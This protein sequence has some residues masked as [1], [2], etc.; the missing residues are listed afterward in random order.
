MT[1]PF[2]ASRPRA[3]ARAGLAL[4][5]G[6]ALAG[7]LKTGPYDPPRFPFAAGFRAAG[8]DKAVPVLLANSAWWERLGD[9]VLDR[10]VAHALQGNPGIAAAQARIT[11]ARAAFAATPGLAS[12]GASLSS[13]AGLGL[14]GSDTS[15][16]AQ[17]GGTLDLGFSWLLDP[18]GARRAERQAAGARIT[19]AEA[20]TDAARL[21][22]IRAMATA[23]VDLRYSQRRLALH[24]QEMRSRRQT[25]AMTRTLFAAEAVT[26]LEIIRSEGRLAE[27]EAELPLRRAAI[28]ARQN[29]IAVLAG[30]APGGA[31]RLGVN[32]DMRAAQPQPALSPEVGIPADLLRNRPDIRI[33][34]R[35]Y[36]IALADLGQAKAALY[37]RLSLAGT[38]SASVL[39]GGGGGTG[40]SFG[41][42]LQLPVLPG[43][44]ARATVDGGRARV[45]EAHALWKSTVL[46][47]I[48]EVENALIDYRAASASAAASEKAVRLYGE[49]LALTRQVFEQGDA[50]LGD[51]IDAEQAL[52]TAE[53]TRAGMRLRRGQSFVD[54]NT[55]L[56]AGSA[57]PQQRGSGRA[58]PNP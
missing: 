32:L 29:E 56:G 22:L 44:P 27:I 54:L 31:G 3:L 34:E 26:R 51:L 18:Y 42:A 13:G 24:E 53:E 55:R 1:A 50:T 57:A 52:A 37:P 10:L 39:R 47:A 23:Y 45:T 36:Y 8:T 35:R 16:G 40:Y 4:A 38:I 6:L 14:S 46:A 25:L 28:T 12:N 15:G 9:P 48:L 2:V 21:A 49:A 7:C 58:T 5:T 33:A 17:A 11:Q 41:P 20:E 30:V 19:V 43:A